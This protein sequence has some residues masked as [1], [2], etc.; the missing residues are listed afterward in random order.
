[1]ENEEN[2]ANAQAHFIENQYVRVY[3]IVKSLQGQK[4]IQAFKI[5]PIKELN[6]ITYHLLN[7]MNASIEHVSK[8]S[9]LGN[10]YS[11][12]VQGAVPAVNPLKNV[13]LNGDPEKAAAGGLSGICMQVRLAETQDQ[14]R[15]F[16][17]QFGYYFSLKISNVIKQSKTNEGVHIRDICA[18]FKNLPEAKIRET[19]EFLSTEGHVYSTIDDEHFKSTDS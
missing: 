2:L 11:S 8:S 10:D 4:Y 19:L 17:F 14:R 18:Y 5:L 12:A 15:H 13:N 6:E 7:C 16:F 3:G 9:G 1:M